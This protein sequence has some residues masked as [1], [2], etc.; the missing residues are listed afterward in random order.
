MKRCEAEKITAA[1]FLLG[2]FDNVECVAED[3]GI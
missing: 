2:G 1:Q 3:M